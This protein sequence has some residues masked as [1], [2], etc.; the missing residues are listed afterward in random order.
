MLHEKVCY[1]KSEWPKFNE[2]MKALINESYELVELSIID[3]EDFKFST[4][5]DYFPVLQRSRI[6]WNF[7]R[8]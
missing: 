4:S 5:I 8:W 3:H 1:K 2:A 6:L 7:V